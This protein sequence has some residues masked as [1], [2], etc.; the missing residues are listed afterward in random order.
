V[1]VPSEEKVWEKLKGVP[2]SPESQRPSGLQLLEQVP[3]VVE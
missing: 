2:C 3:E 1:K